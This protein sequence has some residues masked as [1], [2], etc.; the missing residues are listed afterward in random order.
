MNLLSEIKKGNKT[1][2]AKGITLLESS[3][4]SDRKLAN[5]LIKK[6]LTHK[7]KAIRIGITGA[8][9]VG[10][11]TFIESFGNLLINNGLKVAV[12]AIDPSSTETKG[13][14]LGDKSRMIR[15]SS[16]KNAFIRPSSNKGE[17]G[18]INTKTRE[19]IILCETAGYDIILIETVGVG[20][21]EI[22]IS[23]V[24]DFLL[25]LIL[26]E[27]GDE[28]QGIKRGINEIAEAIIVN[29]SDGDNIERAKKTYLH[30][31]NS[32]TL[33]SISRNI[34]EVRTGICSALNNTGINEIWNM[35]QEYIRTSKE[36]D[37]FNDKRR[38]QDVFWL[39]EEIRKEHGHKKYE[40]LKKEGAIAKYKKQILNKDSNI[41]DILKLI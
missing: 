34:W 38:K 12:L 20:Q 16:N 4:E 17:L 13:S 19:G 5:N 41:Y 31:K 32:L 39:S 6:C 25:L 1:A 21:S 23:N 10:K 35:I 29:K 27:S 28:L 3:L 11:S 24:T 15:L 33:S 26:P 36:H 7:S 8:P 40:A 2:L 30:Y 37:Y 18:G 22:S 14:I 9:G